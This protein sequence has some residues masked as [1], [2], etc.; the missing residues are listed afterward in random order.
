MLNRLR[1]EHRVFSVLDV[2]NG[3]WSIPVR[4]EDQWKFAF[5]V[6][7][8]QLTW[9]R[10]P[11]GLHNS[12]AMF[13]K[14]MAKIVNKNKGSVILQYVDDLL[15]ASSDETEHASVLQSGFTAVEEAGLNFNP[16]K[17]QVGMSTLSQGKKELPA[18]WREAIASLPR[19]TTLKELRSVLGVLNY[20][21]NFVWGYGS[22]VKPLQDQVK[23]LDRPQS[24]LE[25]NAELEQVFN[26]IKAELGAA[27]RL[28]LPEPSKVATL[29]HTL[30]PIGYYASIK[31]SVERRIDPCLSA[32][33]CACWALDVTEPVVGF[34]D[35]IA[36]Y[37]QE[38]WDTLTDQLLRYVY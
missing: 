5:S 18:D 16:K 24:K 34:G 10:V 38:N 15:L 33:E 2:S 26:R 25:W 21:M 17:M 22:I 36:L 28:G 6:G 37:T 31:G 7:D 29:V 23:L 9:S 30:R 27:P 32:V 20:S 14:E 13:H 11:Q 4:I 35:N 1:P 19:P 8:R 12:P 3:F